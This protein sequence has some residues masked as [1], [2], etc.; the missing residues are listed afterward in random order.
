MKI[1]RITW[2]VGSL[3]AVAVV[4]GSVGAIV[5]ASGGNPAAHPKTLIVQKADSSQ[6]T[7]T[8][9]VGAPLTTATSPP[10]TVA[11]ASAAQSGSPSTT[12]PVSAAPGAIQTVDPAPA[13]AP[14]TSTTTTTAAPVTYCAGSVTAD[15]AA[16]Q[17][18]SDYPVQNGQTCEDSVGSFIDVY[19]GPAGSGIP[20]ALQAGGWF[21]VS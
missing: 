2:G 7:T 14:T 8:T 1:P 11:P 3:L 6:S 17:Y 15:N 19:V 13:Q 18:P 4:G 21:R 5:T 10:T 20:D 9:T 12:A 16:P